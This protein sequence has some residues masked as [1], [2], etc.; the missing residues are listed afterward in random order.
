MTTLYLCKDGSTVVATYMTEDEANTKCDSLR[1]TKANRNLLSTLGVPT[2][3]LDKEDQYIFY[4]D[5]FPT[6]T[7]TALI[8]E[9]A[10]VTQ[11]T[12]DT[13]VV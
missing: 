11:Y 6:I 4:N 7:E 9:E 13:Q 3:M 5:A 10:N 12:V 2:L 1:R 8:L